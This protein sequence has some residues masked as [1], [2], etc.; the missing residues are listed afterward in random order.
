MSKNRRLLL[1]IAAFIFFSILFCLPGSSIP[2]DDW[3][4]KIWADKWVH[5][6]I[7]TVLV[8]LW[9]FALEVAALTGF[10]MMLMISVLY[11]LLVEVVQHHFIPNRS[12]DYGDLVADFIGSITG[13]LFWCRYKKNKPL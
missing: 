1:A 3:L 12:F 8:F 9:S 2:K 5:I 10:I 11:G 13:I 6:G 4:G 7:F